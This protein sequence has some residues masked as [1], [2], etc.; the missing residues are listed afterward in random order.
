MRSFG[1]SIKIDGSRMIVK[2]RTGQSV[3]TQ[4]DLNPVLR[5]AFENEVHDLLNQNIHSSQVGYHV[6]TEIWG[7]TVWILPQSPDFLDAETD[8]PGTAR[9]AYGK[10]QHVGVSTYNLDTDRFEKQIIEKSLGTGKGTGALILFS[11]RWW[12]S[13][14]GPGSLADEMLLHEL[15]HAL[16]INEG[17]YRAASTVNSPVDRCYDNVEEFYA[18]MVANIFMSERG[19]GRLRAN[20][21][22]FDDLIYSGRVDDLTDSAAFYKTYKDDI[23]TF[24]QEMSTLS[25]WLNK[26]EVDFNPI[27]E[28]FKD[29]ASKSPWE[30]AM[31]DLKPSD[32]WR[33]GVQ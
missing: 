9:D 16:R 28:Y 20:H 15:V 14:Q 33:G 6:L 24:C 27:R 18:I 13:D 22:G 23:T 10:G 30:R 4:S 8:Y 11:P 26:I 17:R 19:K 29:P 31:D 1:L 3:A 12:S 7:D 21:K 25:Y 2:N 32:I 5:T